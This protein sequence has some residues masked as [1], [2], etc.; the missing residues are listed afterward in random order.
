ML[1]YQLSE[2]WEV[3]QMWGGSGP[4]WGLGQEVERC[5]K[6]HLA[7]SAGGTNPHNGEYV[8]CTHWSWIKTP[9]REVFYFSKREQVCAFLSMSTSSLRFITHHES[10]WAQYIF[11]YDLNIKRVIQ[12]LK[13]TWSKY[14]EYIHNWVATIL[15]PHGGGKYIQPSEECTWCPWWVHNSTN[16]AAAN[17]AENPRLI[18]PAH[19]VFP[20]PL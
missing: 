11:I 9:D 17:C 1:F 2:A 4:I 19:K 16:A 10:W 15:M 6:R 5:H 20:V 8:C 7:A 14:Q 3:H 12:G 13:F 18:L